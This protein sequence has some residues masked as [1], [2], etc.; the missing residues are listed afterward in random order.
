METNK[1]TTFKNTSIFQCVV[2]FSTGAENVR[3]MS[4][5]ATWGI[6]IQEGDSYIRQGVIERKKRD[7]P[8]KI[9]DRYCK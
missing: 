5:G 4:G 9:W 8:R 6:Y 2:E 1:M 7:T 3:A